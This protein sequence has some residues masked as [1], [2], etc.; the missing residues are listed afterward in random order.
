MAALACFS[1]NGYDRTTVE[2]IRKRSG[3]STGSIYHHFGGKE[4]LAAA[5]YREGI[6]DHQ[7][8]FVRSLDGRRSARSGIMAVVTYHLQWVE[9]H[10]EWACFLFKMR[11]TEFMEATESEIQELNRDFR[12]RVSE[13]FL[14]H[15][16]AGRLRRMPTDVY[17]SVLLGPCQDFARAWLSGR[18][19]TPLKAAARQI[20]ETTWQA[21]KGTSG[22]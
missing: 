20:A 4:Q 15:V 17:V 13:W 9:D 10:P 1:D 19:R 6:T 5:V 16:E 7:D 14:P 8:G 3:A 22:N 2:D 11:Q 21:V 12:R 18:T